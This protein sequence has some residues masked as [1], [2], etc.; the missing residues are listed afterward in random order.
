MKESFSNLL[1]Y[2]TLIQY[3]FF[4]INF[5][6]ENFKSTNFISIIF[7]SFIPIIQEFANIQK[8]E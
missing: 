3:F 5:I 8:P 1:F 6:L 7:F 2:L 4:D